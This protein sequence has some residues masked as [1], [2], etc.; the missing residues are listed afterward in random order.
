M[1]S[2]ILMAILLS[3]TS[4]ASKDCVALKSDD[5]FQDL[6]SFIEETSET[7]AWPGFRFG[8]NHIY[9]SFIPFNKCIFAFSSGVAIKTIETQVPFI[10]DEQP[11]DGYER[12]LLIG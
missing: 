6:K 7:E 9:A 4:W 11:N 5:R 2:F 8:S 12:S 1:N 10:T 3:F